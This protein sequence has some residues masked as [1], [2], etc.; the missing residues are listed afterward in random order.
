MS[1]QEFIANY[2]PVCAAAAARACPEIYSW[3]TTAQSPNLSDQEAELELSRKIIVIRTCIAVAGYGAGHKTCATNAIRGDASPLFL[4][5]FPAG[6][7]R[8]EIEEV[9]ELYYSL[10]ATNVDVM[11]AHMDHAEEEGMMESLDEVSEYYPSASDKTQKGAKINFL[12]KFVINQL[13][14]QVWQ[15]MSPDVYEYLLARYS[16]HIDFQGEDPHGLGLVGRAGN[17][18]LFEHILSRYEPQMSVDN[19]YVTVRE[20]MNNEAIGA[21]LISELCHQGICQPQQVQAWVRS[22]PKRLLGAKGQKRAAAAALIEQGIICIGDICC[23]GDACWSQ[24]K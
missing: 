21:N 11:A 6:S 18:A 15:R 9:Q 2:C 5:Q 16:N 7:L 17:Q 23:A 8:E 20:M 4:Y 12:D 14:R 13:P 10:M 24:Y 1:V 22:L 19:V 3:A